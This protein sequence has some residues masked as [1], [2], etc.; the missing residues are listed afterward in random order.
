MGAAPT[1]TPGRSRGSMRASFRHPDPRFLCATIPTIA[2][3]K[4]GPLPNFMCGRPDLKWQPAFL[5]HV[6]SYFEAAMTGQPAWLMPW[7][8]V[9]LSLVRIDPGLVAWST[10]VVETLLAAALVLGGFRKLAYWFA[11]VLSAGIWI[12]AEGFGGP[13]KPGATDIGSSIIYVLLFIALGHLSRYAGTSEPALDH[14]L[15]RRYPG[16]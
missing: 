6:G 11:A 14:W 2:G 9:W 3:G 5:H 15:A 7:F 12:T 8:H 13:F 16:L 10:A 1:T 4:T